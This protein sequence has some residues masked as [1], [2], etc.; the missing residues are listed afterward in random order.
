MLSHKGV[1]S[2]FLTWIDAIYSN[3]TA[4]VRTNEV[5][6]AYFPL[7]NITRQGC[8]LSPLIFFLSLEPFLYC[9]RRNQ[10]VRGIQ[11]GPVEQKAATFADDLIFF[12]ISPETTPLNLLKEFQRYGALSNFKIN[13]HKSELLNVSL[14]T[15]ANALR[16][17]FS[18]SWATSSITYLGTKI[19]ST[20]DKI[21]EANFSPILRQITE[22]LRKWTVNSHSWMGRSAIL[23]MNTMPRLLYLFQTLPIV[24][25]VSFLGKVRSTLIR[26]VWAK[27]HPH[28]LH[29]YLSLPKIYG[30]MAFPDPLRYFHMVHLARALSWCRD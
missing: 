27:S 9:I 14:S 19:T 25:P 13:T 28:L 17:S 22:D 30:R 10:E 5:T 12:V 26:F 21:F 29:S 18:F 3:P 15:R 8:S 20:L 16:S 4:A 24:I 7:S 11:G 6:I 2:N 23:K 1:G